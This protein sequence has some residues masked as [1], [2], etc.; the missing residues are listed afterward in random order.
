[1]PR[2]KLKLAMNAFHNCP[3][4][5]PEG[6]KV[7]NPECNSGPENISFHNP[8]GVEFLNFLQQISFIKFYPILN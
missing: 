1:M 4:K 6:F 2:K 5:S 7:N 3:G 8:E